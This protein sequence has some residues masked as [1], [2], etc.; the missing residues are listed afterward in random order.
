MK[1]MSPGCLPALPTDGSVASPAI[2]IVI[3][4]LN[5]P[6]LLR[7]CLLC[8]RDQSLDMGRAEIIVVDNGSRELPYEVTR[9]FPGVVLAREAEAGPGPARNRGVALSR[10]PILAFIDSDCLP[11]PGWAAA[12]LARFADAP[13]LA[14]IGGGLRVVAADPEA[15]TMAEAFD[16]LYGFRQSQ[17][18]SQG[19]FAATANMATRRAVFDAVGPFGGLQLSED[20][21][22]GQRAA[23][24]GYRTEFAPEAL[25]Q[26]PARRT[27]AAL[28]AQWGRRCQP[29]LPPEHRRPPRPGQMGSGD[30]A[31][32]ALAAGRDPQRA[33]LGPD[34][35]PAHPRARLRGLGERAHVPCLADVPGDVG[36]HGR[37]GQHPL[38]PPVTPAGATQEPSLRID[39]GSRT[40]HTVRIFRSRE[41]VGEPTAASRHGP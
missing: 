9:A 18:I 23:R 3:P 14:I 25:V 8:L 4:H 17:N 6:E 32:G 31:D 7:A 10:A 12:I 1:H 28:H 20:R 35:G 27:M 16:L 41:T 40:D 37:R 15:P 13:D 36:W 5:Q 38:E 2:S 22:W 11:D 29:F 39:P 26:H 21:D 19:R 33:G 30:P 24:M 34:L